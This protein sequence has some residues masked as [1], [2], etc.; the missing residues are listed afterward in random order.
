MTSHVEILHELLNNDSIEIDEVRASPCGIKLLLADSLM[1]PRVE[2][3]A[4]DAKWLVT[5]QRERQIALE[6]RYGVECCVPEGTTMFHVSD[7]TRRCN[8]LAEGLVP[9]TGGNTTLLRTYPLRSHVCSEFIDALRF[10]RHQCTARPSVHFDENGVVSGGKAV[11]PR[12]LDDLDLYRLRSPSG[13][14]YYQ[15]SHFSGGLWT[16]ESFPPELVELVEP[17]DW[18]PLYRNLYA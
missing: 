1:S 2:K 4:A 10:A 3:I 8:I 9:Q 11:G 7:Q 6:P 13:A 16:E 15:D 18:K 17:A 14:R 5:R 12:S